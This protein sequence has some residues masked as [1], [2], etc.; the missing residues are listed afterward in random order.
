MRQ[1]DEAALSELPQRAVD[2][3]GRLA[4]R[5]G[6][7]NLG[8][9]QPDHMILAPN[10]PLPPHQLAQQIVDASAFLLE[11]MHHSIG[12]VVPTRIAAID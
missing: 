4:E 8:Q 5:V 1:S 6:E 2:V 3:Y 11:E 10:R 12:T 9:R 7:F